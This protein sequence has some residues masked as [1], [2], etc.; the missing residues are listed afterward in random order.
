M[1]S[2]DLLSHYSEAILLYVCSS[3]RSKAMRLSGLYPRL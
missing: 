3:R 2:V 1:V